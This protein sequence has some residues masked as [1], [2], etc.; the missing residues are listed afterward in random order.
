MKT[1]M[2]DVLKKKV[3]YPQM[4]QAVREFEYLIR[5]GMVKG[6]PSSLADL[7]LIA[8]LDIRIRYQA[9]LEIRRLIQLGISDELTGLYNKRFFEEQIRITLADTMRYQKPVCVIMG[10]I[11]HFKTKVNDLH[12]HP[13]GDIVLSKAA[14]VFIGC[15][16]GADIVARIGGDEFGFILPNTPIETG[17][18]VA[19]RI[20]EAIEQA[21]TTLL[22]NGEITITVSAGVANFT[23]G[24]RDAIISPEE[25]ISQA[26]VA[27]Y[28]AKL[29]RNKV[30]AFQTGM[31]MPTK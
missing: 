17:V 15:I 28:H 11:D 29:E 26:D 12:G 21:K 20:R 23:P 5:N 7:F 9:M 30:V 4:A 10:D 31:T 6:L 16:R 14:E 1:E 19:E 25:L 13:N 22:N 2:T 8:E 27:L 3:S 24:K 18:K